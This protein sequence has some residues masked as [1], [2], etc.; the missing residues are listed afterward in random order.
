MKDLFERM[1]LGSQHSEDGDNAQNPYESEREILPKDGQQ[2]EYSL[3]HLPLI[4]DEIPNSNL[5]SLNEGGDSES[6]IRGRRI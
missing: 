2:T 3:E 4:Y 6:A 5:L 1:S